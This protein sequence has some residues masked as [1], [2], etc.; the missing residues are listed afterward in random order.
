MGKLLANF[1]L[2]GSATAGIFGILL[3]IKIIKF[4]LDTVIHGVALHQVYGFSFHLLG[5]IWDSVTQVLLH[6][7]NTKNNFKEKDKIQR[8]KPK[9]L[10][11]NQDQEENF[12][13]KNI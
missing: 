10:P 11:G 9:K 12:N 8:Q 1:F 4:G 6:W 2:F 7:G 5:A 13:I 3:T